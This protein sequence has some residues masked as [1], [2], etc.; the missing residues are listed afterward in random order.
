MVELT[1]TELRLAHQ[2]A[3]SA[4][5]SGRG[6]VPMDDLVQE[7]R[8]W[9]VANNGK[10]ETWR[11][12]GR[13]GQN[14]VRQACRQHCLT[15]VAKERRRVSGLKPGDSFYYSTAMVADMLPVIWDADDWAAGSAMT[16]DEVRSLP[17]PSEGNNRLAMIA[18]IRA[19]FA[20]LRDDEQALLVL[21]HKDGG[22][23]YE[24]VA[25]MLEVH[26][27]T[28]RRR[29]ERILERMVETLGGLNP[30]MR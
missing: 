28:V 8:L 16:M 19:A 18:D 11:E 6:I 12:Q 17:R 26:E 13:H 9:L 15:V 14:K 20:R 29:E 27:R 2:G 1:D 30:Y 3:L 4:A 10:V 22:C 24:A 21:L 7:A 25:G 23:T 5:R